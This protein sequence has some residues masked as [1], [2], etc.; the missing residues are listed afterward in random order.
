VTLA[1]I[2]VDRIEIP[3][4]R[5][6]VDPD[7]VARL[8]NSIEAIGLQHPITV[9]KRDGGYRLLA[10]AHRLTA[11]RELGIERILA[12][13]VELDDLHAEL[14]ELDENLAR[15]DLSPAERSAAVARR[16][17]IYETL[18]PETKHGAIG[19]GHKLPNGS[20]RVDRFSAATAAATGRSERAVQLDAQRGEALGA[21]VLARVAHTSLD[22][23]AELDAL[24]KLPAADRTAVVDRA[25]AGEVVSAKTAMSVRPAGEAGGAAAPDTLDAF[26]ARAE[27]AT[28]AAFYTGDLL[29]DELIDAT[30]TVILA[31]QKFLIEL[32]REFAELDEP[33]A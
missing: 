29:Y 33:V 24:A 1:E 7:A 3:D 16:K 25:A 27:A 10:G 4:G 9:A 20:A 11:F 6:A 19:R 12:N 26:L 2:T 13:V 17:A 14:V 5:R 23:G 15:N 21:E 32:E 22:K 18:H 30:Q 31:W 28:K 8:K